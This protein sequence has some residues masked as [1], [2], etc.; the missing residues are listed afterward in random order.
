MSLEIFYLY[1]LP[2][3]I[4]IAGWVVLLAA[5]HWWFRDDT[6]PGE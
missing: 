3:L 2:I 5:R 1:V 6:P 4:A